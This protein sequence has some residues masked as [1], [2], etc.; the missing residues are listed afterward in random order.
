MLGET[1]AMGLARVHLKLCCSVHSRMG[2]G[3][4][5]HRKYG[6]YLDIVGVAPL[7]EDY[8]SRLTE[9]F[10]DAFERIRLLALDPYDIALSKLER[11]TTE[12]M[13]NTSRARSRGSDRASAAL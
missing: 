5:L 11:N 8:E 13:S 1:H 10:P 12:M 7:P 9:I 4:D 2:R 6:V 3:S